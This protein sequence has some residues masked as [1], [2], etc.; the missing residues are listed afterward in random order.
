MPGPFRSMLNVLAGVALLSAVLVIGDATVASA[1]PV[2][3]SVSP[4]SGPATGGTD[5]T[6]TGSGFVPGARVLIGQGDGVVMPIAATNVVFVS[7]TEI[8][9]TTGGPAIAGTFTV[10]V[11]QNGGVTNNGGADSDFTYTPV[12]AAPTV[13]M[14]S[15]N[16]GPVGGGTAITITGTGFTSPATVVIGQGN[17]TTRAV[18]ATN[19]VVASSTEITATTGEANPTPGTFNLFVTTSGGT[20]AASAGS[21]FTYTPTVTSVIPNTGPSSGG[22]SITINGSGFQSPATVVIGQGN[23]TTGAIAA[24]N[25]DVI[26]D[27][28]IRATTGGG[29]TAGTFSVFVTTQGVTTPA[30]NAA[31]L[32]LHAHRNERESE[33]WPTSG[34]T[35]ITIMGSGFQSPATVVIGQGNGTTG[36][37]AATNVDVISN[38]EITATTGGGATAGTFSVYVTTQGVTSLGSNAAHFTYTS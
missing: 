23:G 11:T 33:H 18:R 4:N 12:G 22:T 17:G 20:S 1:A 2:V 13:T 37:I 29:A 38:S 28:E 7:S 24:T 34:G 15:P 35:T 14:I 3:T 31:P 19:V 6:I 25:V 9:A 30:S 16:S 26:A 5:I 32:H 36:A 27:S 8:T 10:F 21:N